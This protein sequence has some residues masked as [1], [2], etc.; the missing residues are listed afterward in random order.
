MEVPYRTRRPVE[1][2]AEWAK[3][4]KRKPRIAAICRC[5]GHQ[6]ALRDSAS[7]TARRIANNLPSRASH[8]Q[9]SEL[10]PRSFCGKPGLAAG[11]PAHRPQECVYGSARRTG[12]RSRGNRA[13]AEYACQPS[14]VSP[15]RCSIRTRGRRN[16]AK[17]SRL[18][19]ASQ[20]ERI[21]SEGG[22]GQNT[23]LASRPIKSQYSTCLVSA[24]TRTWQASSCALS[25]V[26]GQ[27]MP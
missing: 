7:L 4:A 22:R 8:A 10:G 17:I 21:V 16:E 27:I 9:L 5:V 20:E 24:F 1:M 12:N 11:L 26:G 15:R 18:H 19:Q 13:G 2:R 14:S 3:N 25:R 6:T 23:R